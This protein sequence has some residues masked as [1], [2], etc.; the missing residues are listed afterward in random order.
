MKGTKIL[1]QRVQKTKRQNELYVKNVA[2]HLVHT[3]R[4]GSMK[5]LVMMKKT[6]RAKN[7]SQTFSCHVCRQSFHSASEVVEHERKTK[8]NEA[9]SSGGGPKCHKCGIR[10]D[11]FKQLYHHRVEKHDKTDRVMQTLQTDPWS[12]IDSLP[13]WE[14]DDINDDTLNLKITYESTNI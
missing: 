4:A 9:S 3:V 2:N 7:R 13:P 11:S 8:H 5:N 10:C 12:D 1:V 6:V 14:T